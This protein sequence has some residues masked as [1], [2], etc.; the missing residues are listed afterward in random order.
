[1]LNLVDLAGSERIAHTGAEGMRLK[2]G[3]HINKS[4]LTLS[5][6]I[7]KL[8]DGQRG[9]H[10]PYRDSKLTRILQT[11]LGGNAL[12]AIICTVTPAVMHQEETVSTLNFA[13]RAKNIKNKPIVNEVMDDATL[14]RKYKEE[15]HTLKKQL[16]EVKEGEKQSQA[17]TKEGEKQQENEQLAEK[18]EILKRA[19]LHSDSSSSDGAVR[20][21]KPKRSNRR[22]TWCPGE[23]AGIGG[24]NSMLGGLDLGGMG[25][26]NTQD[27]EFAAFARPQQS[28]FALPPRKRLFTATPAIPLAMPLA[29]PVSPSSSANLPQPLAPVEAQP[30]VSIVPTAPQIE[31]PAPARDSEEVIALREEVERLQSTNSEVQQEI[32]RLQ[33]INNEVLR[34]VDGLQ[35]LNAQAQDQVRFTTNLKCT[36][37]RVPVLQERSV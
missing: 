6:V 3:G 30:E 1:M 26:G 24:G 32:G 27:M 20:R 33:D 5:T 8:S 9:Q 17:G 10:I 12:T 25:G 19:I 15:I 16:A 7:A 13:K 29:T 22:E 36:Q 4:L 34:Q 21:S 18:L 35:D 23:G 14:M 31:E 28:P 37:K 11:A 2:E